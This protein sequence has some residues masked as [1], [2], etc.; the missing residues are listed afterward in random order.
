MD[1]GESFI[2]QIVAATGLP[3]EPAL[4]EIHR[5]IEKSGKSVDKITLDELR[6]LLAT[7][8][9]EVLVSTK[10]DLTKPVALQPQ[11]SLS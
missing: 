2:L 4:K 10:R 1:V 11:K 5:L 3:K 7:Y 6:L 9:Q 8:L